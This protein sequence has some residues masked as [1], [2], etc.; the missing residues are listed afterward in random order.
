[1]TIISLHEAYAGDKLQRIVSCIRGGG[2]LAYPTDTLYG[3]GGDF[4]NAGVHRAVDRLKGRNG[5]PYS[6][7]V[8]DMA[9]MDQLVEYFPPAFAA[10]ESLLPGRF[11]F[12]LPAARHLPPVLTGGTAKVGVRI[13]L[14]PLL[15]RLIDASATPWISTSA[16]RSGRPPLQDAQAIAAEF[17]ELD[18]V[19]D[20]GA[21]PPSPGSTIVDLTETPPRIVR[22]GADAARLEEVG[23]SS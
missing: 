20:G 3:L 6:A 12:L 8:S 11:T 5:V 7:A 14:L 21:L 23:L 18:L 17:P 10:C 2:L 22:F 19:I 1:M 4:L 9:M 15:L 13:P 16:N